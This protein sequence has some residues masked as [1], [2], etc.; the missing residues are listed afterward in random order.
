M[1]SIS[2]ICKW[3]VWFAT[4]WQNETFCDRYWDKMLELSQTDFLPE[5]VD[6]VLD[7]FIDLMER[8]I[9]KEFARFYGKDNTRMNSFYDHIEDTREFFHERAEFIAEQYEA[10]YSSK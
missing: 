10:Y 4:M 5:R 3:D 2:Y 7:D 8:P 1:D 9:Q 6:G